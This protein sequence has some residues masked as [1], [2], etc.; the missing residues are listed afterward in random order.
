M[1]FVVL[2]D[3][4]WRGTFQ[5]DPSIIG[6]TV[7]IN[8]HPFTVVGITS[9]RFHGTERFVW[10]D[11]WIPIINRQQVDGVDSL[12]D[13]T[14]VS[15][16][17]IGRLKPSITAGP[18]TENLNAIAAQLAREYPTTDDGQPL[19]L[20]HPGLIGDEGDVIRRFL[21]GVTILAVLVLSA[22]C[23]NLASLFASRVADRSRE[24]AIRTALGSDRPWEGPLGSL[25]PS[26]CWLC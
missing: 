19:R 18:T 20:I 13:R 14:H 6:S 9:G 23:V 24:L 10:P 26:Y 5:S 21:Y 4:L 25:L 7:Q 15:V 2:S 11:Y 17:V 1:P 3:A 8:G 16:T 12:H 22:A